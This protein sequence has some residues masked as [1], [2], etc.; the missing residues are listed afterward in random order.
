MPK[1]GYC[2]VELSKRVL[3]LERK[4][5]A[6]RGDERKRNGGILGLAP[7]SGPIRAGCS[8]EIGRSA[9]TPS[10]NTA[11]HPVPPQRPFG[12]LLRGLQVQ[13][14][15]GPRREIGAPLQGPGMMLPSGGGGG[16]N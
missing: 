10:A 16:E 15:Q 14:G 9:Q 6:L 2:G 12:T 8:L 1:A 3:A 4:S 13:P 7:A 5:H 11:P